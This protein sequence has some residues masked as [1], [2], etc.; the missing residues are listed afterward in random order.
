MFIL[1]ATILGVVR[2]MYMLVLGGISTLL[3]EREQRRR[4]LRVLG[5]WAVT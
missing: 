3:R 1:R 5:G 4:M 2:D